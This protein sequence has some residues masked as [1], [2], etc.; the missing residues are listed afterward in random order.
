MKIFFF[1]LTIFVNFLDF[2]LFL[3]N[4][5]TNDFFVTR[6]LAN[7]AGRFLAKTYVK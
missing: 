3:Y 6:K 5:K 7:N 1:I 2:L 4:K